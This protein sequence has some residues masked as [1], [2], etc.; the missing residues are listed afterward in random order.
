M[1]R[2]SAPSAAPVEITSIGSP[3]ASRATSLSTLKT[4]GTSGSTDQS[5]NTIIAWWAREACGT[6]TLSGASPTLSPE[7]RHEARS[8]MRRL[9]CLAGGATVAMKLCFAVEISSRHRPFITRLM[10]FEQV[11][12]RNSGRL[13]VGPGSGLQEKPW[14]WLYESVFKRK[15]APD[16]I[17][18]GDRFASRKRVKSTIQ[19]PVSIRSKRKGLWR[20]RQLRE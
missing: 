8:K 12:V 14:R 4:I 11:G 5:E 7:K 19:S 16:L 17:R 18:G 10:P 15:P 20:W 6:T 1:P 2:T 9:R 3:R 13:L